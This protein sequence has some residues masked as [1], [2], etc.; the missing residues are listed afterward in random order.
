M[1]ARG[2]KDLIVSV[3]TAIGTWDLFAS[4]RPCSGCNGHVEDMVWFSLCHG[5]LPEILV[6]ILS[7]GHYCKTFITFPFV[8]V[9]LKAVVKFI[10]VNVLFACNML[11]FNKTSIVHLLE[12]Y[13]AL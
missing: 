8:G 12:F 2:G 10:Q 11:V 1:S 13:Y 5:L 4:A 7:I 3:V 9:D 6:W